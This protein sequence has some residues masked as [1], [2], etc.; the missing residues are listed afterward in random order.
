MSCRVG[1]PPAVLMLA[2][3]FRCTPTS[4]MIS[5]VETCALTV[6]VCPSRVL[7]LLL[8][9]LGTQGI[10]EMQAAGNLMGG[11]GGVSLQNRIVSE[12]ISQL[13]G[14]LDRFQVFAEKASMSVGTCRKSS[15]PRR[16]EHDLTAG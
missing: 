5:A 14:Y 11:A 15:A 4:A 10:N 7:L 3:F 1:T 9:H 12:G 8:F 16:P 2:D 6:Q 13:R